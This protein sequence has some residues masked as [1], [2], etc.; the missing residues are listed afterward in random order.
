MTALPTPLPTVCFLTG[1][2]NAFA[3]AER[4]TAVIA[5]E[6]TRHG[7]EVHVLSLWD[8]TSCFPLEPGLRHEALF[9]TRPSFKRAYFQTVAAVRQYVRHHRIRVLVEVDTML[10]LFT[11]PACVGLPV[12][13]IAWEHCHFDQDLGRV[14]R[15]LARRLAAKTNAAIVV[16]TERDGL[17]W[18][19]ALKP[20]CPVRALPNPLPFPYPARPAVL[21][22]KVVLAAGRLTRAKGFDI[23]LDAWA[24]VRERYPQWRLVIVGEGEERPA[25]ERR[26]DRLGLGEFVS[27]PG[28]VSPMSEAY[29]G[30]SLFCLS[31][32]YEGFGLV[33]LEA[34]AYGLPIVS[35]DCQAGPRE[36]LEAGMTATLVETGSAEALARGLATLMGD[37]RLRARYGARGR[38]RAKE[39]TMDHVIPAWRSLL[40]EGSR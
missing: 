8:D 6:L 15:R 29:L 9:P 31:S 26:R 28:I 4:M 19:T 18:T 37:A 2:L 33:L 1:T 32:R 22:T 30:A 36:L 17:R 24:L 27:M 11:V 10:T 39:F 7:Y 12:R 20:S 5:N 38:E 25:L 34:M 21:D 23:L 13:R 3:G 16:L 40:E 35:T 14:S